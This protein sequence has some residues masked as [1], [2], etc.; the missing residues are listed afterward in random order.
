MLQP[1]NNKYRSSVKKKEK[2]ENQTKKNPRGVSF[3]LPVSRKT[4]QKKLADFAPV[5]VSEIKKVP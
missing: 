5:G 4:S 2:N 1:E 3:S